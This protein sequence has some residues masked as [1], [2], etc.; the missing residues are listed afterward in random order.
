MTNYS[1]GGG[2]TLGLCLTKS[3]KCNQV[4]SGGTKL[5]SRLTKLT[6]CDPIASGKKILLDQVELITRSGGTNWGHV[7]PG[8]QSATSWGKGG[9]IGVLLYQLDQMCS[10]GVQGLQ[11][12]IRLN[13]VELRWPAKERGDKIR[14]PFGHVTS[15]PVGSTPTYTIVQKSIKS[16]LDLSYRSWSPNYSVL[17]STVLMK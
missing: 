7:W 16:P 1:Q 4:G 13:Q 3:T 17:V 5:G 6:K 2:T 12:G 15:I 9:K 10:D 14:S 11:I 8:R